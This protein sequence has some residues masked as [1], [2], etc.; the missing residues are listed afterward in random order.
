[1]RMIWNLKSAICVW[2]ENFYQTWENDC[3]CLEK[4]TFV[5]V[6][7][8]SRTYVWVRKMWRLPF[9]H[10]PRDKYIHL[11]RDAHYQPDKH[12]VSSTPARAE[13]SCS[14]DMDATDTAWLRLLNAERARAGASPVTEDQFEKVIEELEVRSFIHF[15]F[16]GRT[17]DATIFRNTTHVSFNK[18]YPLIFYFH[19]Y[20]QSRIWILFYYI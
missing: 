2:Y 20:Y 5:I 12:V 4:K 16:A 15:K 13:A 1:M 14:Y 6:L 17:R 7:K 3:R 19:N 8:P 11:A 10:R 9:F 18:Y